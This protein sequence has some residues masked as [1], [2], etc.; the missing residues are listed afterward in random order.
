MKF[1]ICGFL[2][3][4]FAF[5]NGQEITVIDESKHVITNVKAI[6][7]DGEI[8]G[9]TDL[10]GNIN[11]N[12][13]NFKELEF[14]HSDYNSLK[15]HTIINKD[16][17]TLQNIKTNNIEEVL[18]QKNDKKYLNLYAFF[19]SYQLIDET[20]Q[21]FTDGIIVY[22]INTKTKKL[23]KTKILNQ[24]ILKNIDFL[25]KFYK[26]NPNRTF[27]VGSNITP[28]TFY[29]ELINSNDIKI[30]NNQIIFFKPNY[31]I[32]KSPNLK[33]TLEY[34]SPLNTKKQSLLGLKSEVTNHTI[35]EIFKGSEMNLKDLQSISKYYKSKI[36]QK[37]FSY[38]YELIQDIYIFK[39]EFTDNEEISNFDNSIF[40]NQ[41]P[42]T[43]KKLIQE[44]TLK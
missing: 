31:T 17:I 39:P 21:S 29:E 36:S 27:S 38:Q 44:K 41:I 28:L 8:I 20:P 15:L 42:E 33:L 9:I 2:I 30:E 26:E 7:E 18:I 5:F 11:L 3:F 16:S 32:Q 19:I 43:I 4:L 25:N 1:K 23:K 12:N 6:N 37:D 35:S 24:R 13:K 40:T 22:T 34:N 14:F 10:K